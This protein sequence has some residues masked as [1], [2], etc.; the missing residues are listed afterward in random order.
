MSEMSLGPFFVTQPTQPI[1]PAH[2]PTHS[3]NSEANCIQSW[4]GTI[5]DILVFDNF[6]LK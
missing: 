2:E 4:C 1:V 3:L 6:C 5:H